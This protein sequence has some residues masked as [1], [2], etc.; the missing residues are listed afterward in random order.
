VSDDSDDYEEFVSIKEFETQFPLSL[1]P[2][3]LL[4][5]RR[6]RGFYASDSSDEEVGENVVRTRSDR[7]VKKARISLPYYREME[8][9]RNEGLKHRAKPK[10]ARRRRS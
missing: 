2:P 7:R 1:F 8:G 10:V 6:R 9:K 3:P 4:S 5:R